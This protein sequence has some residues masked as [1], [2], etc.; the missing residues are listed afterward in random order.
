MYK[1]SQKLKI[2]GK[3]VLLKYPEND[4]AKDAEIFL[5]TLACA[6]KIALSLD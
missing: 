3:D 6:V 5:K 4:A 2:V 1:V